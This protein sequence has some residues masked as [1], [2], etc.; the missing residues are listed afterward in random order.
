MVT[1]SGFTVA[2][3]QEIE[4]A[5]IVGASI[6]AG[7]LIFERHDGSTFS[8]GSVQGGQPIPHSSAVTVTCGSPVG[9]T[10]SV[11]N[12]F[13]TPVSVSGFQKYQA[14]TK[15]IIEAATGVWG[16]T[17]DTDY[18]IAVS[19]SGF[20]HVIAKGEYNVG[21][22]SGILQLTGVAAG[23]WSPTLYYRRT[24]GSGTVYDGIA[25]AK[26]CLKVTETY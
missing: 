26:N 20:Y 19:I 23:T 22:R 5:I 21:Q 9:T 1:V 10:S 17:V 2:K 6:V 13:D 8:G 11:F 18:E 3:S 4:D 7:N 16:N 25:G 14:G 15:L 12:G 24:A